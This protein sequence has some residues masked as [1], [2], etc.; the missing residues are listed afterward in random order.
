MPVRALFPTLVYRAA[1]GGREPRLFNQRLLDEAEALRLHDAAGRRWSDTHYVGGYTSYATH[2]RL[3]LTSS[4]FAELDRRLKPHVRTFAARLH[5][6]L[7]GRALAMTDCWVNFMPARVA[8]GMHLH[9]LSVLSGTYYVQTPRGSA[10]LK[11]EDPRLASQMAA[12]PRR[13]GAPVPLRPFV[14]LPSRAGAV[15]LFESWLR[16][17]VPATRAAG[18]RVS[19]S[20]NYACVEKP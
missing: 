10:G 13:S 7:R 17:E 1:L 3:H 5:Y 18:E 14:T 9:P 19:I 15:I 8:H 12:P 6:D 20:F 2:A 11:L 4:T 16:H